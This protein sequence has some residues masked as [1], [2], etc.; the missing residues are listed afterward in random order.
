MIRPYIKEGV[1]GHAMPIVLLSEGSHVD[2]A[3]FNCIAHILYDRPCET[4][5]EIDEVWNQ[6]MDSEKEIM[7]FLKS[8]KKT[9]KAEKRHFKL[10]EYE[11]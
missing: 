10:V 9:V 6:Q 1:K 3:M 7:K 8:I 11:P 4:T 5:E 2:R